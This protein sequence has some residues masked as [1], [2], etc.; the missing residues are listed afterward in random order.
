MADFRGT[1][2]N[3]NLIHKGLGSANELNDLVVPIARR[4][5]SK[6]IGRLKGNVVKRQEKC[7][8]PAQLPSERAMTATVLRS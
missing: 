1:D 2:S 5:D 3:N 4:E 7:S 8:P 6:R